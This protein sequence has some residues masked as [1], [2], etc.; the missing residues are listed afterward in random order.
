MSQ[1]TTHVLDTSTGQPA[2]GIDIV[3]SEG[4][5]EQWKVI[6]RGTTDSEGRIGDLLETDRSLDPGSYRMV[7]RTMHC[8][9]RTPAQQ[10]N[11]GSSYSPSPPMRALSS[12]A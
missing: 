2:E 8:S 7:F 5:G 1:I 4:D 3:L 9:D 12:M 10:E 6:A 11:W